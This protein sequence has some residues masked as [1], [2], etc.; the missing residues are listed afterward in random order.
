MLLKASRRT[1]HCFGEIAEPEDPALLNSAVEE[2]AART[3]RE[4][5]ESAPIAEFSTQKSV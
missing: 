3:E 2:S 4:R 5:V 1:S